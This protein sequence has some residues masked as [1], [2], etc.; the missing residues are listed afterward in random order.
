MN[1]LIVVTSSWTSSLELFAESCALP[2]WEMTG[3]KSISQTFQCF[4]GFFYYCFS[5]YI[6]LDN[7]NGFSPD[8]QWVSL[9]EVWIQASCFERVSM[10]LS[11]TP[12]KVTH[13]ASLPLQTH[14]NSHFCSTK[15]LTSASFCPAF[16][17]M[18]FK[19][20]SVTDWASHHLTI[21]GIW[22]FIKLIQ[23]LAKFRISCDWLTYTMPINSWL[24]LVFPVIPRRTRLDDNI[25]KPW[26]KVTPGHVVA[27]LSACVPKPHIGTENKTL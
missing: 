13:S 25:I 20:V 2:A 17:L 18:E 22:P 4:R 15:T 16:L 3:T 21:L 19:S 11:A 9:S 5:I 27:L 1:F 12:P 14:F 8:E 23:Q 26:Q 7:Y 10:V 24:D 6:E